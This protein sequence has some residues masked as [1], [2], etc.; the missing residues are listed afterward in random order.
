M[1]ISHKR[2][3]E[4]LSHK[5]S[6]NIYELGNYGTQHILPEPEVSILIGVALG[7]FAIS[8]VHT[9]WCC[10]DPTHLTQRQVICPAL[11]L[12]HKERQKVVR[13]YKEEEAVVVSDNLL[14]MSMCPIF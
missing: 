12:S 9:V 7:A 3:G 5:N 11:V 4:K 2:F 6:G 13:R 14:Q 1:K 10:A 8:A